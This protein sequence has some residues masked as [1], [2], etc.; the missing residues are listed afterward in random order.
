MRT[1]ELPDAMLWAVEDY[2]SAVSRRGKSICVLL[3]RLTAV[4]VL[5]AL[6][7]VPAAATAP[8][9]ATKTYATRW[10]EHASSEGRSIMTFNTRTITVELGAGS[11]VVEA[12]FKNTSGRTITLVAQRSGIAVS[13]EPS[14]AGV[15]FR[16]AAA[17]SV[18]P[19]FPA[20]LR[21]AQVW[22]GTI[23]GRGI[24]AGRYLAA[25]YGRW[26]RVFPSMYP[27]WRWITDHS[28]R[29]R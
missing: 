15:P 3:V 28:I 9:A 5:A 24:P 4:A 22:R 16:F 11:W 23:R 21:P 26:Y 14:A 13:M 27:R 17:R 12:S 25:V 2:G 7:A 19:A 18:E 29:I 1:D 6:S 8:G 10:Q 20:K